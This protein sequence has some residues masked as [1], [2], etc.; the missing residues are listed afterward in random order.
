MII[1]DGG[2][3]SNNVELRL[4]QCSRIIGKL[5][6]CSGDHIVAHL[7]GGVDT[8]LVEVDLGGVIVIADDVGFFRKSNC[9]GHTNVAQT[10]QRDFLLPIYNFFIEAHISD[11]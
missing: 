11:S 4:P 1:I 9:N 6:G 3:N 5:N 7:I 10:N 8:T 2:G